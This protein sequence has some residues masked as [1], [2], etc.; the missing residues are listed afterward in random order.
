MNKEVETPAEEPIEEEV[1]IQKLVSGENCSTDHFGCEEGLCCGEGI[2]ESDVV[3][4][5]V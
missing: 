5:V 3:N 2:L 1:V 4:E